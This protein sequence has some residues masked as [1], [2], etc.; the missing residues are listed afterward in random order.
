VVDVDVAAWAERFGVAPTMVE[1]EVRTYFAG[2]VHTGLRELGLGN[3]SDPNA[4]PGVIGY[5]D[6]DG[7]YLDWLAVHP[8]GY[9]INIERSHSAWP[10]SH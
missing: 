9:V 10:G 5:R 1:P 2:L 7:G 3:P 8:D 6:D 4:N